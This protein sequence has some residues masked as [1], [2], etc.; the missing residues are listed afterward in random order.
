MTADQVAQYIVSTVT[1][2]QG[3]KATELVAFLGGEANRA[4]FAQIDI[5]EIIE[6]LVREGQ[7]VEIEYMVPSVPGRVKSFLLPAGSQVLK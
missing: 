2:R 1:G 7:I 5:V 3:L 6:R 4:E